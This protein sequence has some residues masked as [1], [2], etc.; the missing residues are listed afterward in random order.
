MPGYSKGLSGHRM[1]VEWCHLAQERNKPWV[2]ENENLVSLLPYD[3]MSFPSS[4]LHGNIS[5]FVYDR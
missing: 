1:G 2:P 4:L 3:S 5:V